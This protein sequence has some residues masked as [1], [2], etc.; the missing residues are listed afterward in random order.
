MRIVNY[1][2]INISL[3][4]ILE[5]GNRWHSDGR[6][7]PN[8][9]CIRASLVVFQTMWK[10][11][12]VIPYRVSQSALEGLHADFCEKSIHV[13]LEMYNHGEAALILYEERLSETFDIAA[14]NRESLV[15]SLLSRFLGK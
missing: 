2:D 14:R 3:Q 6:P 9:S 10:D 13:A 5:L 8:D 7:G 15:C 11:Y 4:E 1:E 12:G